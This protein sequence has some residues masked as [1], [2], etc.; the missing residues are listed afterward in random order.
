MFS[1]VGFNVQR[2]IRVQIG[3]LNI[4][5]I[6]VSTVQQLDINEVNSVFLSDKNQAY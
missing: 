4:S 6:P 5:N 3:G 1:V 2:L